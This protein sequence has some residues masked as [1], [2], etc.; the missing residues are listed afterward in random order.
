MLAQAAA[1]GEP[2]RVEPPYLQLVLERLWNAERERGSRTLRAATLAELGGAG[3][4]VREH[5][6]RALSV[7]D[8]RQRDAAALMFDHLVTPSGTKVAH[9]TA[10]L[11]QFA[12]VPEPEAETVLSALGRERILRSLDEGTGSGVRFEIFHDVLAG[13]F[14]AGGAAASSSRSGS[15]H[16]A[17]VAT[18]S[19]L[20]WR[21]SSR[22]S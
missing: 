3:A 20:H 12:R 2:D 13:G 22:S 18:S 6:D 8:D 14:S 10:D 21:H 9:R 17:T 11:A 19:R 5:L 7:L 15:R 16:V 4:I 1:T